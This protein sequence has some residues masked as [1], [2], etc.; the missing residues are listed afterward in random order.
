MVLQGYNKRKNYK[1][2][3]HHTKQQNGILIKDL[4]KLERE[5]PRICIRDNNQDNFLLQRENVL[6]I[7]LFIDDLN[8]EKLLILNTDLIQINEKNPNDMRI[9][10]TSNKKENE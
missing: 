9:L 5:I 1:L 7:C 8:D 3:R 10:L 6:N 2:S 4:S